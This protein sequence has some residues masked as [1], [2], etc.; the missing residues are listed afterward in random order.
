MDYKRLYDHLVQ[1]SLPRG[2]DKSALSGYYEKHH[3]RPRC[4]GGDDTDENF[5]LF[6]PREHVIAH[7]L[8]CKMYPNS[9][10]LLWAYMMMVNFYKG[11]VTSREV[12]RLKIARAEMMSGREV[13]KETREKIREAKLGSKL[14]QES[15]AKRTSKVL[16]SKRSEQTRANM[17]D[18]WDSLTD[19]TKEARLKVLAEAQLKAVKAIKGVKYSDERKKKIGE[20]S[21]A[22]YVPWATAGREDHWSLAD[23]YYSLWEIN[24][25]ITRF[26][27]STLYNKLHNDSVSRI[28][29]DSMVKRFETGWVPKEDTR[30]LE[31]KEKYDSGVYKKK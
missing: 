31:F 5:V 17:R 11:I 8:L 15:I 9:V 2:L 14:S 10:K 26:S 7:R 29:F 21:K 18:A 6:T 23:Y 27:F 20:I 3:I 16:G 4:M 25:E 22:V 12:E 24:T 1:K 19:E 13:S 28:Y 30:W